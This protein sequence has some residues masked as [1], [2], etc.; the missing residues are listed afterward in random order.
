[1][2]KK[3]ASVEEFEKFLAMFTRKKL[4]L[5]MQMK[6]WISVKDLIERTSIS[7]ADLNEEI[8]L[9]EKLELVKVRPRQYGN[10]TIKEYKMDP[11]MIVNLYPMQP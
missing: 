1:M 8:W 3:I 11:V 6:N 9:M 7:P 10:T 2:Y 5:L 4:M